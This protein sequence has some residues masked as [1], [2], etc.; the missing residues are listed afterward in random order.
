MKQKMKALIVEDSRLAR[1]ELKNL[2]KGHPEVEI[3]GEA[4]NAEIALAFLEQQEVDLLFLDINMPGKNGFEFLAELDEVPLVI[5]T[6][7]YDEYAIKAFEVNALDY[8]LKP[9]EAS[10]L[11]A[12]L[13]RVAQELAGQ[14][15][16]DTENPLQ[17]NSRIFVKDGE[18][19]WLVEIQ[20]IHR[21]ESVGNYTRIYFKDQQAMV[22]KSLS[23]IE[24][25]LPEEQFFRANRQELIQLRCIAEIVPWFSGNLK[26]K[27]EDGTE[28]EISRRQASKFK[29]LLSL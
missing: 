13:D 1:V 2:L 18:Q 4:A 22:H 15:K 8:L 6:T 25:R 29:K 14:A 27:M 17:Q 26:A 24:E 9:I 5:F 19:C 7:A 3:V 10:R 12:A 21:M 16:E 28:V 11:K 20:D 23:K